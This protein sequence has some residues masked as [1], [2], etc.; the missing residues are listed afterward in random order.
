MERTA[1]SVRD[2]AI[3]ENVRIRILGDLE[4]DRIPI[5]LRDTL[6]QL[7]MDTGGN[8]DYDEKD[9]SN[10]LMVCL[11]IN[12]GGRNDIVRAGKKIAQLIQ[13]GELSVDGINEDT[14]EEHL[15]TSGVPN[16]DLIIRTGGE[17][18]LSN[19][20]LYDLAYSELYFTDELW[21]DFDASSVDDALSWYS[22]RSRRFGGRRMSGADCSTSKAKVQQQHVGR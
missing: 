21:P 5:S 4:D 16:P 22:S 3:E 20:L 7:E 8:V 6:A 1:K 18:R 2:M 13:R 14:F 11:A 9:K 12:Y 15:C 19:F 10:F 17:Q